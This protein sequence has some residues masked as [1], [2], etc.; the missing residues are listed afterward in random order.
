M[1]MN[2]LKV[3]WFEVFLT[4]KSRFKVR[5]DTRQKS[6]VWRQPNTALKMSKTL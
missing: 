3:F 6:R 4:D 5:S 1:V 2:Y